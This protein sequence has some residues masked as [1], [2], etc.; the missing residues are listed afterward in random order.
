M[1]TNADL[2]TKMNASEANKQQMENQLK[3][4]GDARKHYQEQYDTKLEDYKSISE[5]GGGCF[6]CCY[7]W[8]W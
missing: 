1:L 5:I 2:L 6:I 3:R 4:F 8:F 7:L